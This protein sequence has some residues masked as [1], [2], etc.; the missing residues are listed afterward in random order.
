TT[1]IYTLSLHDALP[2]SFYHD[3]GLC[4]SISQTAS[5]IMWARTR[6][7]PP[8]ASPCSGL[9]PPQSNISQSDFRRAVRSSSLCRLVRPY[10]LRLNSP[11]LPCSHKILKLHAVD[12]NPGSTARSSPMSDIAFPP[13]P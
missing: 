6:Q 7:L 2:I 4:I 11:D 9:S 5:R 10:K 12:T 3:R 8:A 13:S 1:E